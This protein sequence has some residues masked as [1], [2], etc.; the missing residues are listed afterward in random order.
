MKTL[1]AAQILT[2]SILLTACKVDVDFGKNAKD[3]PSVDR[4]IASSYTVDTTN[5]ADI[6]GKWIMTTKDYVSIAEVDD[7][8]SIKTSTTNMTLR[9]TCTITEITPP[10]YDICGIKGTLSG[11]TFTSD[12]GT[13]NFTLTDNTQMSGDLSST[14]VNTTMT[15]GATTSTTITATYQMVKIAAVGTEIGTMTVESQ[16]QIDTEQ[17]L[18]FSEAIMLGKYELDG[19]EVPEFSAAITRNNYWVSNGLGLEIQLNDSKVVGADSISTF[20]T[21]HSLS[22]DATAMMDIPVNRLKTLS[23][24]FSGTDKIN[25]NAFN[26]SFEINL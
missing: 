14:D 6:T 9:K 7:S 26:G 3:T 24:T 1:H 13:A 23:A 16:S 12:D 17:V 21:N 10:A 18:M 11:S 22:D 20:T 8:T 4:F 19:V 2:V 15:P 25:T 5:N